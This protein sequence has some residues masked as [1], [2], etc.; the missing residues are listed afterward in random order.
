MQQ[1]DASPGRATELQHSEVRVEFQRYNA[2]RY[3]RFTFPTTAPAARRPLRLTFDANV[4]SRWRE[5]IRTANRRTAYR[6]AYRRLP[7]G[8]EDAALA[9]MELIVLTA[10][11]FE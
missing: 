1:D 5:H 3:N 10:A 4:I 7:D 9:Q 8:R 6:D 2:T 11:P